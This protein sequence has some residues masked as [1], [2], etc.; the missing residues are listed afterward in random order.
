M[1]REAI[2]IGE[3]EELAKADALNQLGLSSEDGVTF[4]ILKRAEKRSLVYLAEVLL[5]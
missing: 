2:G 3:T 1:T 5:K 4:E